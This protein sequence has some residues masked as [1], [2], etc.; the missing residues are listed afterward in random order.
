MG[1]QLERVGKGAPCPPFSSHNTSS[2]PPWQHTKSPSPLAFCSCHLSA[3]VSKEQPFHL[4]PLYPAYPLLLPP[5]YLLASGALPSIQCPPLFMLPQDTSYPT[6]AVPSMLMR[7]SERGHHSSCG[8]TLRPYPGAS[9][10]SAQTQSSQAWNSGL[11]A[12]G[13]YS[14][15][16]ERP[17]RAAPAKR[18]PPASRVGTAAL[19]YPLKKENGKILYECNVCSKSFGQLSNL[20]VSVSWAPRPPQHPSMTRRPIL[21][22]ESKTLKS[23]GTPQQPLGR[24]LGWFIWLLSFI[25][26]ERRYSIRW[27]PRSSPPKRLSMRPSHLS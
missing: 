21:L 10:T 5:P 26:V 13:I 14:P 19:P 9:Q 16:L 12:A 7:V 4:R 2:P 27:L 17:G 15:G 1:S 20:K 11:G 3:P 22:L 8:E 18:A 24:D 6:G 23:E 25:S